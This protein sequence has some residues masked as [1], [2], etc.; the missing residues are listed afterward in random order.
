M[1]KTST[2]PAQAP[3]R[4]SKKSDA[5]VAAAAP[6]ANAVVAPVV[7]AVAAPAKKAAAGK[8][9]GKPGKNFAKIEKSAG[10]GAKGKAIAGKVLANLRKK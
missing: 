5:P 2:A 3:K 10:G 6:V 4:V 1:N 7:A 9:I 8:D